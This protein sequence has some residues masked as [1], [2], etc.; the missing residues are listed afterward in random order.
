MI[1]TQP[2][3]PVGAS[4]R[5]LISGSDTTWG[6]RK[7][8]YTDADGW[9]QFSLDSGDVKN[10]VSPFDDIGFLAT[11]AVPGKSLKVVESRPL[12]QLA[13]MSNPNPE[14]AGG[15]DAEG[16]TLNDFFSKKVTNE[17]SA[18]AQ[19]GPSVEKDVVRAMVRRGKMQKNASQRGD[20]GCG[21]D[22][23]SIGLSTIDSKMS[24]SGKGK[25]IFEIS[26][27]SLALSTLVGNRSKSK[28]ESSKIYGGNKSGHSDPSTH[29]KNSFSA[30][31]GNKSRH[32][33]PSTHSKNS[34]SAF[35]GSKSGHSDPSAHSKNSFSA[36][37][38]SM[39][40]RDSSKSK[41]RLREMID[42]L[43]GV[44]KSLIGEN[45]ALLSMLEE[46]SSELARKSYL[47]GWMSVEELALLTTELCQFRS[48]YEN[49]GLE[50]EEL[51]KQIKRLDQ[52]VDEKRNKIQKL[53]ADNEAK[54]EKIA[55]LEA[56]LLERQ[57]DH[58]SLHRTLCHREGSSQGTMLESFSSFNSVESDS[59]FDDSAS[60]EEKVKAG[61]DK[62]VPL[63]LVDNEGHIELQETKGHSEDDDDDVE[64]EEKRDRLGSALKMLSKR[65][66][67]QSSETLEDIADDIKSTLSADGTMQS[68]DSVQ[69]KPIERNSWLSL[70]TK[71]SDES[72][73]YAKKP[74]SW[75]TLEREG[76][77]APSNAVKCTSGMPL[78]DYMKNSKKPTIKSTQEAF[79]TGTWAAS[80]IIS[81]QQGN[82]TEDT[83]LPL[84][85][86]PP[87]SMLLMTDPCPSTR[88]KIQ[89]G[90]KARTTITS[91]TKDKTISTVPS[92]ADTCVRDTR[93]TK[94]S[95]AT[96]DSSPPANPSCGL[97]IST[98][99]LAEKPR[100]AMSF[101]TG[102]GLKLSREL[103]M[104]KLAPESDHASSSQGAQRVD[105]ADIDA[106]DCRHKATRR[107]QSRNRSSSNVRPERNATTPTRQA[108]RRR[109]LS[110]SSHEPMENSQHSDKS[111]KSRRRPVATSDQMVG[112]S[113]HSAKS[114]GGRRRLRCSIATEKDRRAVS[115]ALDRQVGNKDSL[116]EVICDTATS[117]S[118]E[119]PPAP[120]NDAT[121][122]WMSC[123]N[124]S[125]SMAK[126]SRKRQTSTHRTT[127]GGSSTLVS[128]KSMSLV[129]DKARLGMYAEQLDIVQTTGSRLA[130]QDQT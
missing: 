28:S 88:K 79:E 112:S 38:T 4:G 67:R 108:S 33:D 114:T 6:G 51:Q 120:S 102:R 14:G 17:S 91:N 41:D 107:S 116:D 95:R 7:D 26:K 106:T 22:D 98:S 49:A 87:P 89:T 37:G 25:N 97:V 53:E 56:R 105:S 61:A 12:N 117:E 72:S 82:T 128:S 29:S 121:A 47:Q 70:D 62:S 119:P 71:L 19:I 64:D 9:S 21:A 20:L 96:T 18:Q 76:F 48:R 54:D 5:N 99:R 16:L 69:N 100:R 92:T 84:P 65:N 42:Q 113:N 60:Y 125:P 130:L 63:R 104:K 31:G 23:E 46:K 111:N 85:A 115:D 2:Q 123:K 58:I 110:N 124:S 109:L 36:F 68:D 75:L 101:S 55:I 127:G 93:A 66:L 86:P 35:G 8:C 94:G 39:F 126:V 103:S 24:R 122:A 40:S 3:S 27:G 90:E 15:Y 45:Q 59:E 57:G 32:S 81:V 34:F 129:Q 1:Y 43:E 118:L 50:C 77:K 11:G 10:A 73:K 52:V 44:N 80:D 13:S 83:Y 30:F 78:E 74:N